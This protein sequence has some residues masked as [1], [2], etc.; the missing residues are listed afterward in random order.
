MNQK[1][2]FLVDAFAII[3][4]A[5]FAFGTNQRYNSAGLNTSTMLG[6]T[7]TLID[8][9]KKES[10][11]HIAVVFDSPGKTFREEIYPEYKANRDEMPEDIRKAI[12]YVKKIIE[13]MN[14]PMI[15]KP[16]YEADDI[17]GTLSK[18][19]EK[20]G[21]EV[22][23]MTPDKDYAQLVS[24]NIKMYRPGRGG[25]P[26]EKWGIPEVQEKFDVER[27]EQVI[28]I[29]GLWGDSVDNIPGIPGIGEK[30][31]KKLIKQYGSIEKLLEN[32]DQDLKGK[33]RENVL[34]FGQQGLLSKELA[35]IA[36]DVPVEISES[37][38]ELNSFDKE[39]LSEIFAELEFRGLANRL[40]GSA[41]PIASN[42]DAPVEIKKEEPSAGAFDLF[43]QP[44]VN[45]ADEAIETPFDSI[46]KIEKNYQIVNSR[47]EIE[48]LVQEIE[49]AKSFAFD[50]ETTGLDSHVAEVLAMTI[51]FEK[52][53][54]F[55]ISLREQT[56]EKLQL[57]SEVFLSSEIEKIGQNIKYD[58]NILR[59]YG[60]SVE[61]PMFDTMIAHYL[62]EPDLRHG[63]DYLS[64]TFLNYKPISIETLIGKKGKS[65]KNMG[66][67]T[68]EQIHEYACEDA[69][70]TYQ[71]KLKLAPLLKENNTLELFNEI[72]MPLVSVLSEME[73]EGISLDVQSMLDYSV[74][75][76]AEIEE[77]EKNIKS[78]AKE[79][80][81][82]SS[83]KQLGDL[84]FDELKIV[85]KAKKTKSGQ[86]QTNE[87]TLV[88]LKG[89]HPIIEQI[90]DFRQLKKLKST[91]VDV[92]PTL[93]NEKTGKIHTSFNQAVAATG[94]LSSNNPNL[95]NIPI[96][97]EKGREVRKAFIASEGQSILAADYS[98]VEL[99]IM[100]EISGDEGMKDAF[101]KGLDIH[102]ATAAKVFKVDLEAVTREMRAKSKM[103]NFGIIYGI[104]AFGLAQRL[105]ISRKES[106][107]IIKQYFI[108][109]PGIQNYMS[110]VVEK[111]KETGYVETIMGRK[112]FL[113]DINSSNAIVRGYAERN[114]INAPI[115][116]SAADIIKKAM[117]DIQ[118]K[119]KAAQLKSKMI[120][121]VHDELLFDV[122]E[123][124]KEIMNQLVVEGMEKA[125]KTEVPMVVEANFAQSWLDAH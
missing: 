90:L 75:L 105:G 85:E 59:R 112:R 78:Y 3:Y 95:Q 111:A 16:G 119:I 15:A 2:L 50:T 21:F 43:N 73:Y 64:E 6:F 36:L 49:K 97:T 110:E 107:E 7:N 96:K 77:L 56:K 54:A 40:F 17:I 23:M 82:V 98:Q 35:T 118:Q 89:K 86:Y 91:Y 24:E 116:G 46:E 103:V 39:A 33:Q 84:L 55:Y 83:P 58:I 31:S 120:L 69:D 74:E 88:K 52:D 123:D 22:F 117:I 72:E 38:L 122:V 94:R 42:N 114:A 65:Q 44:E 4:R 9:I 11:T 29:L 121:Q 28:D 8:V 12:P 67:L 106:A 34:N 109:Y 20:D 19:L 87:E 48:Q 63:M 10:P 68:D 26:A 76:Q 104:S 100:A 93:V 47:E 14:I 80:I 81:N 45:Q 25:K 37:E 30:T 70:I 62:I 60:I 57:F 113:K 125:V 51:S 1:K 27:T 79:D 66:D 108:E 92:L 61:G 101:K 5:Y 53:Q 32:A 71:L 18:K 99:R 102:T 124:E 115:Q 41:T 13:G